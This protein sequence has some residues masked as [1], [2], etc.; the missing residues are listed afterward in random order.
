[1]QWP[2]VS[3][4]TVTGALTR[5][6]GERTGAYSLRLAGVSG[7]TT[8]TGSY[9]LTGWEGD[10]RYQR[11]SDPAGNAFHLSLLYTRPDGPSSSYNATG[12]FTVISPLQVQI[13]A[14]NLTGPDDVIIPVQ[15]TT[16]NRV[17]N[18]YRGELVI[19]DGFVAT[20]WMDYRLHI[21]L[22][23]DLNDVDDDGVPDL[24]DDFIPPPEIVAG[25][26][27]AHV[28]SGS[29]ASFS[30]TVTSPS[31]VR[32]Q[33]RFNG[34]PLVGATA[35]GTAARRRILGRGDERRWHGGECYRAS[36]LGAASV[37]HSAAQWPYCFRGGSGGI[38]GNSRGN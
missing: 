30:V 1:M 15:S 17:G 6:G 3:D 13:P 9:R 33:W 37:D 7:S 35:S 34:S 24:S 26:E 27:E 18:R 5:Q 23:T 25:P 28:I 14:F 4:L 2:S 10:F 20:A 16:L 21:W 22:V 36:C 11:S 31:P 29:A 19:D 8:Y 12:P 38:S 32:Y